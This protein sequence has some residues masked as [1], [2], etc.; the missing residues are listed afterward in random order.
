MASTT[1]AM[2]VKLAG[3]CNTPGVYHQLS[4]GFKLKHEILV[5]MTMSR[6]TYEEEPNLN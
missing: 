4:G 6:S 1:L 2:G 5:E 3:V